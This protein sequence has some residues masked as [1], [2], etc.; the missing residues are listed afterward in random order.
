MA[1]NFLA[2]LNINWLFL[3]LNRFICNQLSVLPNHSSGIRRSKRGP[4]HVRAKSRDHEIVRVPE[5]VSQGRP[6]TPPNIM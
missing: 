1:S 3:K 4:L 5:K 2:V 6:N